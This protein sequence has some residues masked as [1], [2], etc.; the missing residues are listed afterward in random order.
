MNELMTR[1]LAFSGPGNGVFEAGALGETHGDWIVITQI[2][3]VTPRLNVRV[4]LILAL[5]VVFWM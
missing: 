2:R 3:V 5:M 4:L 1:C